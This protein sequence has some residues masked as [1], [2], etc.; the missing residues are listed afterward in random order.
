MKTII[1]IEGM[2]CMH[3]VAAVKNA[4][5][6]LNGVTAVEVILEKKIAEIEYESDIINTDDMI[7]AIEE[8]GFD[9]S[10]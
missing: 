9:A 6:N 5:E 10:I 3:C 2:S 1:N 4:L 7:S 8:Q